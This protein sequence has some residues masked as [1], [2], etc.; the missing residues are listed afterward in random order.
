METT[1]PVACIFCDVI[2]GRLPKSTVYEDDIVIAI[3]D[4]QP[5][6][7]GHVLVL[8][9]KHAAFLADMDE[10]TGAH[11]FKVTMRVAQAL[12]TSG[13]RCEGIDLWLADGEAAF[14]EIF[15][16]HMHIFPRFKDDSFK[17]EADWTHQPSR[18][19]L[20]AIAERVRAAYPQSSTTTEPLEPEA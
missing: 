12:Y 2:E 17:L 3:M 11:L 13:L 7:Q 9:K 6:N 10:A 16:V 5:I 14:Q 1:S 20:D 19:E 15:H 18:E 8:P 4:T